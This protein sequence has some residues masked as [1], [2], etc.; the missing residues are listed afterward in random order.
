MFWHLCAC[1]FFL[2]EGL[3][4]IYLCCTLGLVAGGGVSV[5]SSG[6]DFPAVQNVFVEMELRTRPGT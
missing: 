1:L 4:G 2:F 6:P 5:A 3:G